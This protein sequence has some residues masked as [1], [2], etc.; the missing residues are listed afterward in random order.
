MNERGGWNREGGD[1]D[2]LDPIE[3]RDRWRGEPF[4]REH[5]INLNI[6]LLRITLANKAIIASKTG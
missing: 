5:L 3:A 2:A 6:T 4:A 1:G